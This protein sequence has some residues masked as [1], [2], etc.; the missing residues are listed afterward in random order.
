MYV[1]TK[2]IPTY[3][4]QVSTYIEETS[5]GTWVRY[6]QIKVVDKNKSACYIPTYL[7]IYLQDSVTMYHVR[8]T[9]PSKLDNFSSHDIS[10]LFETDFQS[11]AH[12]EGAVCVLCSVLK[13][14]LNVIK[15]V[16]K[17]LWV[18]SFSFLISWLS[19]Q[20]FKMLKLQKSSIVVGILLTIAWTAKVSIFSYN[21]PPKIPPKASNYLPHTTSLIDFLL[22]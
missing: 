4:T 15:K 8:I 10:V 1:T 3:I 16:V 19:G 9:F 5:T 12:S 7:P 11:I 6:L 21:V 2:Y 13:F 17:L 20:D 14:F 18:L 22:V